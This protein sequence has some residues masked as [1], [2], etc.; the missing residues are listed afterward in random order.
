[1]K[2]IFIGKWS[3]N[4]Y[5]SVARVWMAARGCRGF[6]RAISS[7]PHNNLLKKQSRA[8]AADS[9]LKLD[10]GH[11]INVPIEHHPTIR[12]MVYNGYFFRWCPIAPSHGT[13][14]NPCWSRMAEVLTVTQQQHLPMR[15]TDR[16]LLASARPDETHKSEF[17]EGTGL[18]KVFIHVYTVDSGASIFN[19]VREIWWNWVP[20]ISIEI[21]TVC[22]Q[23]FLVVALSIVKDTDTM[24]SMDI[25]WRIVKWRFSWDI[26]GHHMGYFYIYIYYIHI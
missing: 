3:I 14:T 5:F 16:N 7:S 4:G 15:P 25:L 10:M 17:P 2:D 21:H 11:Y 18:E 8:R 26:M 19:K 6:C 20:Q 13:F 22:D 9:F 12:Y 23:K 24:D 1:M